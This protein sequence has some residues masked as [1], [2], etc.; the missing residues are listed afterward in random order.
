MYCGEMDRYTKQY[1]HD[2]VIINKKTKCWEWQL[3]QDRYGYGV[4]HCQTNKKRKYFFAHRI[5][6]YVFKDDYDPDLITMHSCDNRIC[7]NPDHLFQGTR[8][9]NTRDMV[10]KGRQACGEKSN[11]KL[12]EQ[13]VREIRAS[14]K[15]QIDLADEYGITQG[16]V[17]AIVNRRTW[18]HVE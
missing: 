17:T 8:Q 3:A 1:I 9:D 10:S 18:K 12:T 11:S 2:R 16:A 13:Q 4:A 14:S 7:C 15:M 6:Y 5:S